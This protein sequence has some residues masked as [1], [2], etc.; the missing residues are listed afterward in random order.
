MPSIRSTAKR[1]P[2]PSEQAECEALLAWARVTRFDVPY[3]VGR[4]RVSDYLI[5]IPNG[6]FFG[7]DRVSAINQHKRLMRA[8]LMP[9]A[10]DY[11][12]AVPSCRFD[13]LFIEMKRKSGSRIDEEQLA[14]CSR[15]AEIGYDAIVCEGAE[16]AIV[17]IQRHLER[18]EKTP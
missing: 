3:G 2:V 16:M 14:F 13:G 12:L 9:G 18:N 8:G 15:M 1:K 5:M 7:R 10:S 11:F 4:A 6:T 17:A